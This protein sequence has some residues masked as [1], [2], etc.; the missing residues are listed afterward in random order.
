MGMLVGKTP[1]VKYNKTTG[2]IRCQGSVCEKLHVSSGEFTVFV[3]DNGCYVLNT[4]T[5]R[6]A[7]VYLPVVELVQGTTLR[8]TRQKNSVLFEHV[9]D[10]GTVLASAEIGVTTLLVYKIEPNDSNY[11]VTES[12]YFYELYGVNLVYTLKEPKISESLID[13]ILSERDSRVYSTRRVISEKLLEQL[14]ANTVASDADDEFLEALN[15]DLEADEASDIADFVEGTEDYE[16]DEDAELTEDD[17]FGD[18]ESALGEWNEDDEDYYDDFDLDD[19]E[20]D[21]DEQLK[22][23]DLPL[24]GYCEEVIKYWGMEHGGIPN[25]QLLTSLEDM[26]A[27]QYSRFPA[28]QSIIVLIWQLINYSDAQYMQYETFKPVEKDVIPN[29]VRL[30]I[31][32]V[33]NECGYSQPTP[34]TWR[35]ITDRFI[36]I[37]LALQSNTTD[38]RI[39]N[40]SKQHHV[41]F[42]IDKDNQQQIVLSGIKSLC[43][44]YKQFDWSQ[45]MRQKFN[46]IPAVCLYFS[47]LVTMRFS[48]TNDIYAAYAAHSLSSLNWNITTCLTYECMADVFGT[49]F[50]Y[51]TV[52]SWFSPNHLLR[53]VRRRNFKYNV[54]YTSIFD[55]NLQE[56]VSCKT[57]Q[58]TEAVALNALIYPLCRHTTM[59]SFMSD[60]YNVVAAPNIRYSD[61]SYGQSNNWRSAMRYNVLR[62]FDAFKTDN[63]DK[64]RLAMGV[65]DAGEDIKVLSSNLLI[66][67]IDYGV[68]KTILKPFVKDWSVMCPEYDL[69]SRHYFDH[70][71]FRDIAFYFYSKGMLFLLDIVGHDDSYVDMPDKEAF[72]VREFTYD[73]AYRVSY[74]FTYVYKMFGAYDTK[75]DVGS[76]LFKT[77][78]FALGFSGTYTNNNTKRLAEAAKFGVIA[79]LDT[80]EWLKNMYGNYV[81]TYANFLGI[82]H[83]YSRL[84]YCLHKT[85]PSV[86]SCIA[87]FKQ[88]QN[89]MFA[90]G[91]SYVA[92]VQQAILYYTTL[93]NIRCSVGSDV[94]YELCMPKV[95]AATNKL[96]ALFDENDMFSRMTNACN[97]ALSR[98]QNDSNNGIGGAPQLNNA[99]K[100]DFFINR[101]DGGVNTNV[102]N[103]PA[104][105]YSIV[106]NMLHRF[107]VK[108]FNGSNVIYVH[109]VVGA[110]SSAPAGKNPCKTL[111]AKVWYIIGQSSLF[112]ALHLTTY[113]DFSQMSELSADSLYDLLYESNFGEIERLI[114]VSRRALNFSSKSATILANKGA[115]SASARFNN[116]AAGMMPVLAVQ[117]YMIKWKTL[118]KLPLALYEDVI[119]ILERCVQYF[120]SGEKAVRYLCRFKS[121]NVHTDL[122]NKFKEYAVNTVLTKQQSMDYIVQLA[123]KE[124]KY[125]SEQEFSR[126]WLFYDYIIRIPDHGTFFRKCWVKFLVSGY[127]EAASALLPSFHSGV[128]GMGACLSELDL[129]SDVTGYRTSL[130]PEEFFDHGTE[131]CAISL[132]R[133]LLS[134]D[135]AD[136]CVNEMKNLLRYVENNCGHTV[137]TIRQFAADV[138]MLDLP[139]TLNSGVYTSGMLLLAFLSLLDTAPARAVVGD[140]SYTTVLQNSIKINK[141]A[142]ECKVQFPPKDADVFGCI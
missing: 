63:L 54:E 10:N 22:N 124:S 117:W 45:I 27:A 31:L 47:H 132:S 133:F 14:A 80:L 17:F 7:D 110:E 20:Y 125:I 68:P 34:L 97:S 109:T 48:E 107:S 36:G 122:Y 105:D 75:T 77:K 98:C 60:T 23:G 111:Q 112:E 65:W 127:N 66:N 72:F 59:H 11:E 116:Y 37:G 5:F 38:E 12:N 134:V 52:A 92:Y 130:T 96:K 99:F 13:E 67:G 73:I 71:A 8:L 94:E 76:D 106:L 82:V 35:Y 41:S 137:T 93:C 1:F 70:S 40:L 57:R 53:K 74:F 58:F 42:V 136:S 120:S 56:Y 104:L 113:A 142:W 19:D 24:S 103:Y 46:S 141:E 2:E 84:I 64:I 108:S 100:I 32:I 6:V 21:L 29:V 69:Y 91:T 55:M 89:K 78:L 43:R 61:G 88:V 131:L 119:S 15:D 62:R 87:T 9:A 138:E 135:I 86:E 79:L 102:W 16:D 126:S 129:L 50:S 18:T 90:Q 128:K 85:E 44:G 115:G 139:K 28:L 3:V 101:D 25:N 123:L 83:F 118:A 140:N 33:A 39:R 26:L 49:P 95:K 51:D 30:A 4:A 121:S 114:S 81:D